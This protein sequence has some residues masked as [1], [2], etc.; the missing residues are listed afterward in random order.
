MFCFYKKITHLLFFKKKEGVWYMVENLWLV[1]AYA[2][3]IMKKFQLP[4]H[5]TQHSTFLFLLSY[6][7]FLHIQ[8]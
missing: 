8:L 7:Y 1:I 6:I 5:R 3:C 2:Y 4:I